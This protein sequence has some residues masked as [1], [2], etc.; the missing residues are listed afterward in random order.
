MK[1]SRRITLLFAIFLVVYVLVFIQSIYAKKT[2]FQKGKADILVSAGYSVTSDAIVWRENGRYSINGIRCTDYKIMSDIDSLIKTNEDYEMI[3][4][5]MISIG[6]L[7]LL[8]YLYMYN[9]DK[10]LE[11]HNEFLKKKVLTQEHELDAIKKSSTMFYEQ[12]EIRKKRLS[13][14][15][16]DYETDKA[17][18]LDTEK[19]E[20]Y[21]SDEKQS[22]ENDSEE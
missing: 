15:I 3:H 13:V 14:E 10:S 17:H 22:E 7:G 5:L 11:E 21:L 1:K 18:P 16:Y 4:A 19:S 2:A 6:L 8:I 20:E 9:Y 12:E